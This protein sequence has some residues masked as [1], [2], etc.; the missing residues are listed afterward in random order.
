MVML[1]TFF[2]VALFWYVLR[3]LTRRQRGNRL[4]LVLGSG[5]HTTE[6]LRL[7]N[8]WPGTVCAVHASSDEH[9][10]L[11]FHS[12]FSGLLFEIPRSRSVGQ[13][14]FTSIFTT[15]YSFFPACW[16]VFRTEPD[17]IISNGP[18]TALPI[19]YSAFF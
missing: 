14:Y 17:L 9:S 15:V 18:G 19:C 13:S 5:G 7:I 6:L 1:S 11:H 8:S 10:K 16:L 4:M 2:A 12:K 3:L